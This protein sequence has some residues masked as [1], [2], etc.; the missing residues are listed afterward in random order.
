[1][2]KDSERY[3][4][5][6]WWTKKHSYVISE[7]KKKTIERFYLLLDFVKSIL[8]INIKNQDVVWRKGN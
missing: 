6:I 1:M 2:K 5:Y 3:N 8:I 4:R 7:F